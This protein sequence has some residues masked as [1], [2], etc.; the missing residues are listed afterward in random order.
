MGKAL[1]CQQRSLLKE[2]YWKRYCNPDSFAAYAEYQRL[3]C[4]MSVSVP[5]WVLCGASTNYTRD[6]I[7]AAKA[8]RLAESRTI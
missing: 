1:I 3:Y 5:R 6:E 4:L 8:N 2:L 7:Q